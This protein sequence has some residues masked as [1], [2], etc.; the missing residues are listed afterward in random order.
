M[1]SSEYNNERRDKEEKPSSM[2]INVNGLS[3]RKDG[4]IAINCGNEKAS[5]KI[6]SMLKETNMS[7]KYDI[8]IKKKRN[9][10]VLVCSMNDKL[11]KEEIESAIKMQNSILQIKL[12][13][14]VK[15]MIRLKRGVF[16]AVLK[17]DGEALY[18]FLL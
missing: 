16:N 14:C 11:E 15:F 18:P 4:A 9:I 17:V 3:D 2:S 6:Q 8:Q 13:K 7:D 1:H 12:L 5:D 10:K